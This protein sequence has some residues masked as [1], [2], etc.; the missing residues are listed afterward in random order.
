MKGLSSKELICPRK[1]ENPQK[2][3]KV[4]EMEDGRWKIEDGMKL[5]RSGRIEGKT[6]EN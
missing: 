6:D 5:K 2:Y 3:D 1:V 4:E